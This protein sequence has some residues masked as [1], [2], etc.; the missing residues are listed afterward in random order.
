MNPGEILKMIAVQNVT[1]AWGKASICIA[2]QDHDSNVAERQ[3]GLVHEHIQP[4]SKYVPWRGKETIHS[5][6]IYIVGQYFNCDADDELWLVVGYDPK[7]ERKGWG[8]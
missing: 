2:D 6:F 5:P 8:R 3:I 1:K 7:V 4:G